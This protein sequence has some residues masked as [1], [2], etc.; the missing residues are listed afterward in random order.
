MF[1]YV[2]NSLYLCSEKPTIKKR[3]KQYVFP[4]IVVKK[5]INN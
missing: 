3:L 1:S 2:R 5:Q 4:H